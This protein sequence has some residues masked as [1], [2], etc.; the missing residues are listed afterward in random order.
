L[1][2]VSVV[3][4]THN[5]S[6]SLRQASEAVLAVDYPPDRFE[7]LIVDNAST[8]DTPE[9]ASHLVRERPDRIRLV[10]APILGLSSARN[11]GVQHA[12][13]E[14]IV[15]GD[16][17]AFPYPD[18]LR[19]IADA[20][21]QKNVLVAGGPV[22]PIFTGA[23]PAWFSDRF[24]PY[25]SAWDKGP[26]AERLTYNDYPR[27]NN[28]A[29]QRKVFERFGSF[30][31]HLGRKGKSLLSC[32]ETEV[33]LRVERDGGTI[34]YVPEA[35]VRHITPTD[36]LTP[37]WLARRFAAQGRS[38]AIVEWKHGGWPALRRGL[39]RWKRLATDA[40]SESGES[41]AEI[42][43]HC[44]QQAFRAYSR[45]RWTAPLTV[46]RYRAPRGTSKW[47]PWT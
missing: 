31:P 3:V 40:A 22:E 28:I 46:P 39:A 23:L 20:L 13:G 8:D 30:S 15:F 24:L 41:S 29:F 21:H 5:R 12:R 7:L 6:A 2:Y 1:P 33:C 27:G 17:D 43:K 26:R 10:R 11:A 47:L 14:V 25:L 19:A 44:T 16:D 38:E 36:R 4:C 9:V 42:Y 18:W 34:L 35:R 45:A 37:E 32:E